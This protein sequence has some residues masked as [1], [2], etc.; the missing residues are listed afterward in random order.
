MEKK[1]IA[2]RFDEVRLRIDDPK[3]MLGKMTAETVY[4]TW[5]E[6]FADKTT[7]EVVKVERREVIIP[8]GRILT[9]EDV[10]KIQFHQSAG[11]VEDVLLTNQNRPNRIINL[12]TRFEV[13]IKHNSK[14]K[15]LVYAKGIG[16][17]LDIAI[18]YCE[19]EVASDFYIMG[20]KRADVGYVIEY[21]PQEEER[22]SYHTVM[23]EYYDKA[24]E[25]LLNDSFLAYS[26]DAEQAID[27]ARAYIL[28]DEERVDFYGDYTIVSAKQSG[29]TKIVPVEMSMEYCKKQTAN[30]Y[31]MQG[32]RVGHKVE[33]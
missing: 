14:E 23:I 20:I 18:D 30:E 22:C 31:I 32:Q 16:M 12:D 21:T 9:D 24:E 17:A 8:K 2:T 7:G 29:I 3:L 13:S 1:N 28:A 6:D 26:K 10:A 27:I 11:D 15:L 19:Q 4:R 25:K 5:T 33:C